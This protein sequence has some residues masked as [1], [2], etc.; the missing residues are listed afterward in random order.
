MSIGADSQGASNF[1]IGTIDDVA[2]YDVALS[3]AAI[4]QLYDSH[5]HSDLVAAYDFNGDADD[6]SG[7]GH[8]GSITARPGCRIDRA[9]PMGR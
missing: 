7:N 6:V 2:V 8:D 1:F 4:R 9:I 3:G 5:T